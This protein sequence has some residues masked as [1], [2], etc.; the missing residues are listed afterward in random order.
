MNYN[1]N[2]KFDD[3]HHVILVRK[4]LLEKKYL[5]IQ[6]NIFS[7]GVIL[8]ALILGHLQF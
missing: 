6:V 2:K 7:L 1:K 4:W 3:D 5:R 8:F